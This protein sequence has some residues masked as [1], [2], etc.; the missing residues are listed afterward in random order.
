MRAAIKEGRLPATLA[1]EGI[2]LKAGVIDEAEARA[3][4]RAHELRRKVIMVDDFPRDL[5]KSEI[6][7][8]TQPVTFEALRAALQRD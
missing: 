2:A 7:Q 4:A 1:D 8:T 3:L 5:G 6:F